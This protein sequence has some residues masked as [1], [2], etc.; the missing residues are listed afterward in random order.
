MIPAVSELNQ[1]PVLATT[2]VR[3][4]YLHG[5]RPSREDDAGPTPMRPVQATAALAGQGLPEDG[6]Y[7]HPVRPDGIESKRQVS[8]ID[9]ATL[10]RHSA[11][12]GT[13]PWDAVKSQIVL[14]GALHLP[15]YLGH[16]LVFGEGVDAVALQLTIPRHPCFAMDLIVPGLRAAMENGQQGAL[17]RVVQGGTLRVDQHVV[18]WCSRTIPRSATHRSGFQKTAWLQEAEKG[19]GKRQ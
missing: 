17:A 15:D 2:R 16:Y 9:E 12:F 18:C 4:L 10:E 11:R 14:A 1:A 7:L 6:R 5:P 8:L 19:T 13:I 3:C